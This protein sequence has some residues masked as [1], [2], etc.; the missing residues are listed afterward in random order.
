MTRIAT[1]LLIFASTALATKTIRD[2]ATGGDG[3][4]IG[5]W[6]QATKTLTLTDNVNEDIVIAGSGITFDG[7]GFT[8]SGPST[9]PFASYGILTDAGL[10]NVTVKNTKV[11]GF[12]F[13]IFLNRDCLDCTLEDNECFG[14]TISGITLNGC[15]H[16][17]TIQRNTVTATNNPVG[18]SRAIRVDASD[19]ARILHNTVTGNQSGI[20]IVGGS[21]LTVSHNNSSG[22]LGPTSDYATG[23]WLLAVTGSTVENNTLNNDKGGLDAIDGADLV[24]HNNNADDSGIT[25]RGNRNMVTNNSILRAGLHV[26]GGDGCV[27]RGNIQGDGPG[28]GIYVASLTNALVE[29]NTANNNVV[30]GFRMKGGPAQPPA[31]QSHNIT[32]RGNTANGNGTFGFQLAA[33]GYTV[34]GNDGDGNG[35]HG[36]LIIGEP[37]LVEGNTFANNG[38]AGIVD[39]AGP[40]GPITPTVVRNN[41]VVDNGGGIQFSVSSTGQGHTVEGNTVTGSGLDGIR[42]TDSGHTV[43]GNTV[44]GS[45]R[46]GISLL[47]AASNSLIYD[48]LFNNAQNVSVNAAGS[49]TWN[50]AATAGPNIVGGPSIGG[51]F[52]ATPAGTGHS[53]TCIDS[54]G[55]GFCDAPFVIDGN[56]VDQ[57]PLVLNTPPSCNPSG[58]GTYQLGDS[59]T[60]GATVA[61]NEGDLV[62]YQWR[63]GASVLSSGTVQTLTGGAPVAIPDYVLAG[64]AVDVHT[65]ELVI[66]DGHILDPVVCEVIVE[67]ID[68]TDPTLAPDPDCSMLWPPNHQMVACTIQAN[69][70][71]ND[72]LPPHLDVTISSNEPDNGLGDGDTRPFPT[73]PRCSCQLPPV[74]RSSPWERR[75]IR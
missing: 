29:N 59:V 7:A 60:L 37:T 15:C 48:N 16:N 56:N 2:D 10:T 5:T 50:V 43:S 34:T 11:T 75:A 4:T 54:N 51:N 64:L 44:T 33:F 42:L 46:F 13:G 72:G 3:S 6:N 67:I 71:D 27:V 39:G 9:S 70:S 62:T 26:S 63:E 45:G 14:N 47:G 55:D 19:G 58:A 69:A 1:A 35:S 12:V 28:E 18:H 49:N 61:D 52:W 24:I 31:G 57:L 17:C 74:R 66:D 65:L 32:L 73:R 40:R 30:A 20:L 8:V 53:E 38:G 22:N 23:I 21:G 41:T 68:T 36:L 25:V